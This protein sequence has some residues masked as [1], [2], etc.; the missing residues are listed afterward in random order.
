VLAK[1]GLKLAGKAIKVLKKPKAGG[2]A[3]PK[4]KKGSASRPKSK[5]KG[6]RR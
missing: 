5:S 2:K 3:K 1:P 6:K 4:A